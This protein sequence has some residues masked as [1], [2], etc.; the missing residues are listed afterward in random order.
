ASSNRESHVDRES[1]SKTSLGNLHKDNALPSLA[2]VVGSLSVVIGIFLIL[3]WI[4]RRTV[5]QQLT[6]LPNEAF[7]VLGRAPLV[8]KQQ[9]HLLRC[10]TKL[11]LVSVT[12]A[13]TETLTEITDPM[14]VD[15]LAGLCRQS[16]PHSATAAFRQIFEQLA[17]KRP[18]RST[19]FENN[20]DDYNGL[21]DLELSGALDWGRN[22]V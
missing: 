7:E 13:G 16:N 21:S 22:D 2:T 5:P 6:R 11:L 9:V 19:A 15:R 1:S 8:G 20:Y 4:L 14:E 12:P 17:P 3:A 18:S 10:G